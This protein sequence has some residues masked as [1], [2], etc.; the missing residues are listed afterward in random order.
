MDPFQNRE[1]KGPTPLARLPVGGPEGGL[2]PLARLLAN[3]AIS[4][5]RLARRPFEP[6]REGIYAACAAARKSRHLAKSQ[7]VE[8]FRNR[9]GKGLTPLARLPVGVPRAHGTYAA[10]T[11]TRGC[12]HVTKSAGVTTFRANKRRD[13]RR[14]RG[15]PYESSSSKFGGSGALSKPRRGG[16]YAACATARG[17]PEEGGGLTP[18]ARMPVNVAI[19]QNLR[20]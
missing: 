10:C 15:P 20:E 13:V 16:T 14:L 4:K 12:R 7:R 18:L 9:E 1:G 6:R 2:T 19:L 11:T 5:I 17:G 8:S 3:V